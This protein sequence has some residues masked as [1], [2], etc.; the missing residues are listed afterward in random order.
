[1]STIQFQLEDLPQVRLEKLR[2]LASQIA[3][4]PSRSVT[5]I[6]RT[7]SERD[8]DI[9]V[10][11]D[12]F[13]PGYLPRYTLD[14]GSGST[15]VTAAWDAMLRSGAGL[16]IVP[17]PVTAWLI[18]DTI[19]W[20]PGVAVLGPRGNIIWSDVASGEDTF[21][22]DGLSYNDGAGFFG[23]A[24]RTLNDGANGLKL[25][26]SGNVHFDDFSIKHLGGGLGGTAIYFD[27]GSGGSHHNAI[28]HNGFVIDYATGMRLYTTGGATA[29]CNRNRIGQVHINNCTIGLDIDRSSTDHIECSLQG[30]D[31]GAIIGAAADKNI[32]DLM[33]ENN[34]IEIVID[35]AS[36][37]NVFRGNTDITHFTTAP[38]LSNI[39]MSSNSM[40]LPRDINMPSSGSIRLMNPNDSGP[41]RWGAWQAGQSLR[42]T[43]RNNAGAN[44]DLASLL[45]HATDPVFQFL[46]P[47]RLAVYTVATLPTGAQGDTA[48]VTDALAP[49]F[50][51][52]VAGSG[53]VV[54]PVFHNGTAWV[55]G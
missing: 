6:P 31:V 2:R 21:L 25:S 13:L 45:Y 50:L 53:A 9:T 54:T 24:L 22:F 5:G 48:I 49:T 39:I 10:V 47:A 36:V 27:G 26:E 1:M 28:G 30:N 14:D 15:S 23:F 18:D 34:A 17:R 33:G 8:N 43:Q 37:N 44:V 42:I 55:V 29:N 51:V 52:A 16:C 35:A 40:L 12:Q 4:A 32:Y 38:H 7:Q 19:T 3:L 11:R 20:Q 41:M 46:R